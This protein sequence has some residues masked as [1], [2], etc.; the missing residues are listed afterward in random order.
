MW[1]TLSNAKEY[2]ILNGNADKIVSLHSVRSELT[3]A[4]QHPTQ[5]QLSVAR[6]KH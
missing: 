4:S 2:R 3:N 1:K 6:T 5:L